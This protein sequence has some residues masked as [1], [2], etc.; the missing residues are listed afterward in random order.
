MKIFEN[1][2]IDRDEMRKLC[3]QNDFY[4]CGTN[5][6]YETMLIMCESVKQVTPER[7]YTIAIDIAVH[8]QRYWQIDNDIVTGIMYLI[9]K[10][11]VITEYE[12][13]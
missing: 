12:I 5:D 9:N 4:T 1:K 13:E 11:A 6:E 7:L 8:T 2:R 3:I 10:H